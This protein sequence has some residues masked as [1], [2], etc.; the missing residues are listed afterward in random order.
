[1]TKQAHQKQPAKYF[2]QVFSPD[3]NGRYIVQ[4]SR[5]DTGDIADLQSTPSRSQA[6]RMAA[7][8]ARAFSCDWETNY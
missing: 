5:Y 2:V 4:A 3:V 6:E 8:M 1:M 7:Q